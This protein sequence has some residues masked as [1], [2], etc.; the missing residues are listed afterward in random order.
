MQMV[1]SWSHGKP[2]KAIRVKSEFMVVSVRNI[3]RSA[4]VVSPLELFQMCFS[5][6]HLTRNHDPKPGFSISFHFTHINCILGCKTCQNAGD[7]HFLPVPECILR[8]HRWTEA[9]V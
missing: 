5:V 4:D 6:V 1:T 7:L 3:L 8:R 9:A 2:Y